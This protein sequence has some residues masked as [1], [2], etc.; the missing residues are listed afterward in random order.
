MDLQKLMR[1]KK[2]QAAA[3]VGG[4]AVIAY[5]VRKKGASSS[6]AATSAQDTSATGQS[7]APGGYSGGVS[8]Y[9]STDPTAQWSTGLPGAYDLLS[10]SST[11]SVPSVFGLAPTDTLVPGQ[12]AQLPGGIDV[13]TTPQAGG[14]SLPSSSNAAS[15]ASIAAQ[16]GS[17]SSA[18]AS[19]QASMA[20]EISMISKAKAAAPTKAAAKPVAVKTTAKAA[21]KPSA[22]TKPTTTGVLNKL[23][24]MP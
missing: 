17:L 21:P 15:V 10:P 24:V 6:T 13:G 1:D 16:I 11:P 22:P 20:H 2:A 4:L 14:G 7:Y 19:T 3:A 23:R 18:L 9:G 12:S 5:V 8:G